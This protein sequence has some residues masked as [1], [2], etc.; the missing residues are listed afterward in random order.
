MYNVVVTRALNE[1]GYLQIFIDHYLNLGFD[2]IYIFIENNEQYNIENSKISFIKHNFKGDD[3]I[4]F[5]F[6]K[7]LKNE[8]LK[9]KIDWV[10][11]VDIDEFLFLR[12]NI[13]IS[14]YICKFYRDNIGQ[15]IFKWVMLENFRS[16]DSEND[17]QIIANQ[18]KLFSNPHYK[19][20]INLKYLKCACNPHFSITTKDK[21]LDNIEIKDKSK[22]GLCKE[23]NNYSNALL[24][25]YHTRNLEN[26]FVKSLSTNFKSRKITPDIINKKLSIDELKE[27]M[28][29]L[30][31]PY[32][33][34]KQIK[35]I[36]NKNNIVEIKF[37]I[38]TKIDNN[39]IHDKL[40]EICK[41]YDVSY[42]TLVNYIKEIELRDSKLFLCE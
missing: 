4:P 8:N 38:N 36:L 23:N 25:H 41:S 24:L 39:I 17:L 14:D 29:K 31:A 37:N 3:V 20:M 10:L 18:S 30:R 13:K 40:K 35:T 34:V 16:I 27:W 9:N 32:I 19:S 2:F 26:A 28:L 6:N 5:I 7:F 33:R 42:I 21:Y 22:T 12:K 15:F 1:H 11:H